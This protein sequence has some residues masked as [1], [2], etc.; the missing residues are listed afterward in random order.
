MEENKKTPYLALVE[1]N[2]WQYVTR[3][4]GTGVVAIIAM[5]PAAELILVEQVRAPLGK[6]VIE[7]PAG[8]LGDNGPEEAQA[9]AQ[10][11]L[12]E[13]TGYEAGHM[14][15][16]GTPL[17][18]SAGLTDESTQ[19]FVASDLTK[20]HEKL[21]VDNEQ[22]TLHLVPIETLVPWLISQ[23]SIGKLVDAKV[24]AAPTILTFFNSVESATKNPNASPE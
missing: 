24:L 13:E 18:S 15:P 3:T 20:K 22:I 10:K 21:G 16:F 12:L 17:P 19:I 7:L 9:C 11:E 1:K 2:G 6:A 4:R 8:L 5:T 23:Q 14:E